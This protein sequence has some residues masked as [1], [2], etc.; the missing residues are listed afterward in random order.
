MTVNN[1]NF[2]A[3]DAEPITGRIPPRLRVTGPP[4]TPEQQGGVSHAYKLFCDAKATGLGTYHVANR[5]LED[6]TTIRM[7]SVSGEDTVYVQT[8]G[9]GVRPIELA[10]YVILPR[11]EDHTSGWDRPGVPDSARA[12]VLATLEGEPKPELHVKLQAGAVDWRSAD[13]KII[14]SWDHGGN[15]RYRT[16]LWQKALGSTGTVTAASEGIYY[17]GTRIETP[18]GVAAAAIFEGFLVYVAD[19]TAP[20][21]VHYASS[22]VGRINQ[23]LSKGQFL[24][25]VS[26]SWTMLNP[27]EPGGDWKVVSAWHFAP[28]GS[29]AACAVVTGTY[30]TVDDAST[31]WN[32]WKSRTTPLPQAK[33]ALT[34]TLTDGVPSASMADT[35]YSGE[36]FFVKLDGTA[37]D[38]G[39]TIPSLEAPSYAG[40]LS[41]VDVALT[42]GGKRL[43]A[44][45]YAADGTELVIEMV[46]SG[47]GTLV[48]SSA[49]GDIDFRT[50]FTTKWGIYVNADAVFEVNYNL[51]EMRYLQTSGG[52]PPTYT[53]TGGGVLL[54]E[55]AALHELDART[56]SAVIEKVAVEMP[57]AIVDELIGGILHR[58]DTAADISMVQETYIQ[59]EM[60]KSTNQTFRTSVLASNELRPLT[61]ETS[62]PVDM[63]RYGGLPFW[64][65]VAGATGAR[66]VH[67]PTCGN[68]GGDTWY[69]YKFQALDGD[70]RMTHNLFA[71]YPN[72][73]SDFLHA[74][75][76]GY[77]AFLANWRFA[78]SGALWSPATDPTGSFATFIAD[79]IIDLGDYTERNGP[80]MAQRDAVPLEAVVQTRDWF[81]CQFERVATGV[82]DRV[83]NDDFS[84]SVGY[85]EPEPV[86]AA[87][88]YARLS[89]SDPWTDTDL[90]AIVAAKVEADTGSPPADSLHLDPVGPL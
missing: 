82:I 36:E 34:L 33:R 27:T 30:T 49:A 43:L 44:V 11:D 87:T 67:F 84:L 47:T 85:V 1:P 13:G 50:A 42:F 88:H 37:L 62:N 65:S 12:Y 73:V 86:H 61:A 71:S 64:T 66:V 40:D 20:A 3:F 70:N 75:V 59:G 76:G 6:G 24:K 45:D 8:S 53:Q 54:Q 55:F 69:E 90:M 56:L 32:L 29:E 79:Q 17:K 31:T 18:S 57:G 51:P 9:G 26:P 10:G 4:L 72:Q 77:G 89:D 23:A 21:A 78:W 19:Q 39:T 5:V 46:R 7:V 38:T 80:A 15:N 16:C 48:T 60:V 14:L 58:A 41:N 52:P 83:T 2:I 81:L 68:F 22:P 63:L 28:D 35:T 25:S 74:T